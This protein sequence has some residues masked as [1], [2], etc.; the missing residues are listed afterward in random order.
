M[1]SHRVVL[2]EDEVALRRLL[3]VHLELGGF[4][5]VGEAADAEGGVAVAA[6]ER[7][8]VV[9]VD[10]RLPTADGMAVLRRLRRLLPA[11][12]VVVYTGWTDPVFRRAA[13]AAGADGYVLKSSSLAELVRAI[14]E[15]DTACA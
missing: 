2:V 13:L 12:R 15:V 9:I 4:E 1:A 5:V 3:R 11:T 8:D 10:L 6:A 7:P 14:A